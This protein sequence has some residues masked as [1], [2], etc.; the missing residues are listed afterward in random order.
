MRYLRNVFY[1]E[2]LW[3]VATFIMN[4]P[5]FLVGDVLYPALGDWFP[6]VFTEI[7]PVT[8]PDEYAKLELTLNIIVAILTVFIISY[9]TVRFDNER[10][11]YMIRRTEGMY[12]VFEGAA[13]YYPRYFLAD[14]IVALVA[15]LPLLVGS[16]LLP[17]TI[18]ELFK[19]VVNFAFDFTHAF[20]DALGYIFGYVTMVLSIFV[21][22]LVFGISSLSAWRGVWLSE[23]G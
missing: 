7:N 23:I 8:S 13:L 1:A 4:V 3:L 22:R 10:M 17:E 19:Y 18:P 11:E 21:S 14:L 2:L 20:T 15:P 12:L 5:E 9:F 16:L 6:T